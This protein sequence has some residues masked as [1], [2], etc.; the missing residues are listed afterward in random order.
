MGRIT[1]G[2]VYSPTERKAGGYPISSL[3]IVRADARDV[4]LPPRLQRP[5][6]MTKREQSEILEPFC[7]HGPG[8]LGTAGE[9]RGANG[10][11]GYDDAPGTWF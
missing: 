3:Q 7:G 1:A 6:R 4:R 2:R 5:G 10:F 9:P 8:D 11:L